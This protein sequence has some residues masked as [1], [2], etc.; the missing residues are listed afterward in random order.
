MDHQRHLQLA[1]RLSLVAHLQQHLQSYLREWCMHQW[2]QLPNSHRSAY[3]GGARSDYQQLRVLALRWKLPQW[4]PRILHGART[5][6]T[7]ALPFPQVCPGAPQ[8]PGIQRNS[9]RGPRYRDVDATISKAFGLPKMPILGENAQ[10]EFRAN[11]YNL[12]NNLN[13]DISQIDNNR[14]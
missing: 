13:L 12:F 10:F 1:Q 3:L 14:D 5:F 8:A 7:C 4:W 2:R 11:S 9:L 6:T